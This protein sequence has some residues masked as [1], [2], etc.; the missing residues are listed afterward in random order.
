MT[1]RYHL[2]KPLLGRKLIM[3]LSLELTDIVF[4][5]SLVT[6]HDL[7]DAHYVLSFAFIRAPISSHG[8]FFLMG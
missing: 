8:I 4:N 2:P 1:G 7:T 6:D 5:P 3:C